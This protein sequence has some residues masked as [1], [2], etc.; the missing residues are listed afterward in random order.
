MMLLL[1]ILVLA[2]AA[3]M[4]HDIGRL[5]TRIYDLETAAAVRSQSAAH[6]DAAARD[7]IALRVAE[8]GASR[9]ERETAPR[10]FGPVPPTDSDVPVP[11]TSIV[12]PPPTIMPIRTVASPAGWDA[13]DAPTRPVPGGF[14]KAL[15]PTPPMEAERLLVA[16]ARAASARPSIVPEAPRSVEDLFGRT[17]PIWAGG[18][19]L[20][21]AGILVVKWSV[22]VGLLSPAVRLIL[23]MIFGLGLV[24]GA[25]LSLRRDVADARI[26][27][28]LAGAGV[29]TLYAC[30]LA[31]NML[32]GLVGDGVA[33]LGLAAVSVAAGAAS[34]R[35]GS[36]S[37]V[38]GLI[39]GLV[40]PALIVSGEPNVPLLSM[41]VGFMSFGTAWLARMQG[42]TWLGGVA[43]AGAALWAFVMCLMGSEVETGLSI[44]MLVIMIG[45]GIPA[46]L[47][48]DQGG[49]MLRM[50]GG[51][52]A[53]IQTAVLVSMGGF[54]I[55]QWSMM[56]A[57]TAGLLLMSERDASFRDAPL[58]AFG[59]FAALIIGWR[60]PSAMAL[61]VVVMVF[62]ALHA[63][64]AIRHMMF[65]ETPRG[66]DAF[67][68]MG[69]PVISCAAAQIHF[70]GMADLS[71]TLTCGLAAAAL[72][73]AVVMAM[74]SGLGFAANMAQPVVVGLGLMAV[75]AQLPH[76]ILPSLLAVAAAGFLAL[77]GWKV[78]ALASAAGS[79]AW[80]AP[81]LGM[82]ALPTLMSFSSGP[83]LTGDLP[84]LW[85]A[86]WTAIP[87]IL[88]AIAVSIRVPSLAVVTR[89]Y[90]SVVGMILA[91]VVW[92][93]VLP[94]ET[95]LDFTFYGLV[96]RTGWE[97]LLGVAAIAAWKTDWRIS[98]GLM[99]AALLHFA[100]FTLMGFNPCWYEQAVGTMPLLNMATVSHGVVLA[101]L[102]SAGRVDIELELDR[103]RKAS[104]M[105]VILSLGVLTLRQFFGGS[106]FAGIEVTDFEDILRSVGLVAAAIGFLLYGTR[107]ASIEWRAGSLF[108]M[109]AAVTKVFVFD[110]SGLDGLARV[111][112]FAALGF[113]LIGIGW[114]YSRMLPG[115][116]QPKAI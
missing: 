10:G 50:V 44:G 11:A 116:L 37:A 31:A 49:R 106:V 81:T 36:P 73:G 99:G 17:L 104:Q 62:S 70:I 102:W 77:R 4:W 28:A 84:G 66:V 35:F 42:R 55:V 13:A 69:L 88:A 32:Y 86:T 5:E 83:L 38:L 110:A 16:E 78:A 59:L 14:V 111:A 61:A 30:V 12:P 39:G 26:P 107:T 76:Q 58:A 115:T 79:A 92:R 19:T 3:K 68:L 20:A 109:L 54:G 1:F 40:A 52:L 51:V 113:S 45:F 105:L 65:S 33:L 47:P 90:A 103:F 101:L 87:G 22:D 74:R 91:H 72:A 9:R 41:Y 112:S 6:P 82:W 53:V 57:A 60:D 64:H 114:L 80:F 46:I 100:W 63:V 34:M 27:Q 89:G 96:E 75:A 85:L 23:G 2:A 56:A 97:A 25:E 7:A 15:P 94:I 29:V 71:M 24:G 8:A 21:I 98:Y 43:M 67:R 48:D 95:P 108:V 18:I 93:N